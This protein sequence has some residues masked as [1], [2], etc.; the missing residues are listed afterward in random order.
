MISEIQN[1]ESYKTILAL[2][3]SVLVLL[4]ARKARKTSEKSLRIAE[5][6]KREAEIDNLKSQPAI[7]ILKVIKVDDKYRVVLFLSNMRSTP[8]RINSVFVEKKSFKRWSLKNYIESRINPNF[9]WY[10]DAVE[11]YFWNP[12]GPLDNSEKYAD[13]AGEYLIVKESEKVLV[14][15][16]DFREHSTYRFTVNTTHGV[17][18]LS[19]RLST[20]GRTHFCN[21]FRQSFS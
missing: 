3:I 5:K 4:N 17:I 10:Y 16:P 13:E 9:D 12:K 20:T 8:F 7:D 6:L 21:E 2:L 19:G 15:I 11:D 1:I 14:T 18:T